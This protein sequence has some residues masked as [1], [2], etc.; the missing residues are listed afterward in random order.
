M[1]SNT[2]KIIVGV[3]VAIIVVLGGVYIWKQKTDSVTQESAVNRI[4]TE[5]TTKKIVQQTP[6]K[7]YTWEST[8]N[9]ISFSYPVKTNSLVLSP[10]ETRLNLQDYGIAD[11]ISTGSLLSITAV[12]FPETDRGNTPLRVLLFEASDKKTVEETMQPSLVMGRGTNPEI[13]SIRSK[14]EIQLPNINQKVDAFTMKGLP[15]L[16]EAAPELSN[17]NVEFTEGMGYLLR[18]GVEGQ[19]SI[20]ALIYMDK[21]F[22]GNDFEVLKDVVLSSIKIGPSKAFSE[23]FGQ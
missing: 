20:Y 5:D 12:E 4:N 3:I 16:Y 17:Q 10:S 11:A 22:A 21:T 13:Y 19:T 1:K 8:D 18:V 14:T 2:A 9:A 15:M 23:K 7:N 6:T